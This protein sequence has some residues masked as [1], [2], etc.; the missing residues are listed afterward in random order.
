MKKAIKILKEFVTEA[1]L[2]F[3][4]DGIYIKE[5]DNANVCMIDIFIPC[6][7][8]ICKDKI[9]G[10]NT[11]DLYKALEDSTDFKINNNFLKI[12]N[13]FL[14]INNVKIPILDLDFKKEKIPEI[15]FTSK[16]VFNNFKKLKKEILKF[17][18]EGIN[19]I[20]TKNEFIIEQE[21]RKVLI[22]KNRI[23]KSIFSDG[24]ISKYSQEYLRQ[25]LKSMSYYKGILQF[26]KD[27]P[28]MFSIK[29]INGIKIN[30]ILAS[31]V[32]ND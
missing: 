11:I 8:K 24:E 25:F 29:D 16:I 20:C 14:K 3:K 4:K 10:I 1:N 28:L 32:A 15:N 7:H 17:D 12:N 23:F 5:L 22:E 21:N 6:K 9:I 19:L 31:R 13:N 27:L 30:W 26:G 18:N 2:T